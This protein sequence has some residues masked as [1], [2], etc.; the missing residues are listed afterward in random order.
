MQLVSNEGL[1]E[2]CLATIAAREKEIKA[3]LTIVK[4]ENEQMAGTPFVVSD[5]LCTQG[6]KTTA[7]SRILNNFIPP[8]NAEVIDKV[9]AAGGLLLGKAQVDEFGLGPDVEKQITANPRNLK[10]VPGG[11]WWLSRLLP[12]KQFL[13]WGVILVVIY[14]NLQPFA[15]LW[16]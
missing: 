14:V 4:P 12:P 6:I 11:L 16:V 10:T 7:G 8:Y 13:L 2:K 15:A 1:L 3:L 9:I 5:N